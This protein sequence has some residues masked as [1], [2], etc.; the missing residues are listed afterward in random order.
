MNTVEIEIDDHEYNVAIEVTK[1]ITSGLK[2]NRKAVDK[3]KNDY[4]RFLQGHLG[5]IAVNK[6][7]GLDVNNWKLRKTRI[8]EL[9]IVEEFDIYHMDNKWEVKTTVYKNGN[10]MIEKN[11]I[12][13]CDKIVL[14][15]GTG[16]EFKW[17]IYGYVDF[18]IFNDNKYLTDFGSGRTPGWTIDIKYFNSI[19]DFLPNNK[20]N[21]RVS[22][23]F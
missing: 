22:A 10:L 5:E 12:P 3:T 13:K 1:I 11:T 17:S 16:S 21:D 9:K 7:F 20:I 23:F 14:V 19:H 15:R 18:N 2:E 8:N 4:S 6:A